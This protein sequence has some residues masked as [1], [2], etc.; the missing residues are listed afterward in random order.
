MKKTN[1]TEQ[2]LL[3][4]CTVSNN[5]HQGVKY[6][7]HDRIPDKAGDSIVGTHDL[8]TSASTFNPVYPIPILAESLPNSLS[9]TNCE[10]RF[11][12]INGQVKILQ[13]PAG[14]PKKDRH[15]QSFEFPSFDVLELEVM[16]SLTWWPMRM[17][18]ENLRESH[19]IFQDLSGSLFPFIF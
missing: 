4:S 3:N 19:R 7:F 13:N 14:S 5:S 6:V 16:T 10:K 8:C 17:P 11:T 12:A 1:Q 18:L 9:S 2:V 15:F